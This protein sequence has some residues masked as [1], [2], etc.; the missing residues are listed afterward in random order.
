MSV[1]H[2]TRCHC[3]GLLSLGRAAEGIT[4]VLFWRLRSSAA[5]GTRHRSRTRETLQELGAARCSAC[6]TR[7]VIIRGLADFRLQAQVRL[8]FAIHRHAGRSTLHHL[9]RSTLIPVSWARIVG[10]KPSEW[11][12]GL[13]ESLD[14]R[15]R[16]LT[17]RDVHSHVQRDTPMERP[18]EYITHNTGAL[19]SS[20][21]PS[22]RQCS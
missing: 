17:R 16:L 14:R 15:C 6:A 18:V 3:C 2:L 19:R 8:V 20:G 13:R 7:R 1:A 12:G 22:I 5:L 4:I 21:L 9:P 11:A 10:S